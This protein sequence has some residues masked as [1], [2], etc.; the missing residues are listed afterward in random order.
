MIKFDV[1]TLWSQLSLLSRKFNDRNLGKRFIWLAGSKIHPNVGE[2][3]MD[4]VEQWLA[5]TY[6]LFH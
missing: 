2:I 4:I 6:I 3:C 5:K 1:Q